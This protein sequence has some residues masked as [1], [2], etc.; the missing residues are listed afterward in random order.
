MPSFAVYELVQVDTGVPLYQTHAQAHEIQ[1]ANDN[2][3]RSGLS[4]RFFPAGTF[5]APC[6][7]GLHG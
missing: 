5:Q 6:L 3:R 7:H 4:S 1:T 2:L